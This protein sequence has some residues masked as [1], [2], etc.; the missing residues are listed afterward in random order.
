M[1]I[2]FAHTGTLFSR[3][4][5]HLEF[6]NSSKEIDKKEIFAENTENEPELSQNGS[7]PDDPDPKE[8]EL[9]ESD[10]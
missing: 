3:A 9:S 2:Y 6:V 4:T 10:D 8:E 5:L 1:S 7:N